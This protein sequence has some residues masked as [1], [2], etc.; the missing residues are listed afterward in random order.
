MTHGQHALKL[1]ARI[2]EGT[3]AIFTTH[4]ARWLWPTVALV[5]AGLALITPVN[6]DEHQYAA[7]AWASG[8]GLRPFV[9]YL[10]LQTP[11]QPQLLGPVAA[12]ADG[13]SFVALRLVNSAA[14]LALLLVVFAA[15]RRAGVLTRDALWTTALC[16]SCTSFLFA[17]SV[18]RNDAL[19]ALLLGVALW[20]SARGRTLDWGL[21]GLALGLAASLKISFGVP[22][23]L[24]GFWLAWQW[25]RV[26]SRDD[27]RR[28][29]AWGVG[30]F[31]GL[32]P[33]ALAWAASPAAFEYG[34][35]QYAAEGAKIWYD[36]NGLSER[37]SLAAKARDSLLV[38]M[39]G[40]SLVALALVA[41]NRRAR[42]DDVYRGYVE[43]LIIAGLLAAV[44]PTPTYR[45]YF[46]VVLP[47]L[48][49]GLGLVAPEWRRRT[50]AR[51]STA[52]L[53]A[54][55]FAVYAGLGAAD[56]VYGRAPAALRLTSQAHWIGTLTR[57]PVVTFSPAYMIDSGAVLDRR[58]VTGVHVWRSGDLRSDAELTALHVTSRRTLA[59]ELASFP[60]AAILTGFEG[61]SGINRRIVPDQILDD[62]A[63]A[64]GYRPVSNP[65]DRGVLWLRPR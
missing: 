20:A 7:A 15:Q 65:Y 31:A 40:P 14:G 43:V 35:F 6:H 24:G 29:L 61:R 2:T 26:P 4:V 18:A 42:G 63:R 36:L 50:W 38:L 62:W 30:G 55:A 25:L 16:G 52:S 10:Y 56:W 51:W 13:W 64:R 3:A 46:I 28:V 45:Q 5:L 54:A 27:A 34:V 1:D 11:L 44:L 49:V 23:A 48:F 12:L 39:M 17:V 47:P 9:D 60:P 59:R 21:A 53:G 22:L 33:T 8:H 37:L 57:G 41:A 19:P 32:L 58:F